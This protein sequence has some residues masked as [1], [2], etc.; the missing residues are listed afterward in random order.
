MSVTHSPG[1]TGNFP[2]F[3][4][5][6][7]NTEKT[8]EQTSE[9]RQT[10]PTVRNTIR[11]FESTK[12]PPPLTNI[13]TPKSSKRQIDDTGS[14]QRKQDRRPAK[15][16]Q[17]EP[18][19]TD[20]ILEELRAMSHNVNTNLAVTQEIKTEMGL[21]K[22]KVVKLEKTVEDQSNQIKFLQKE[23]DR[24]YMAANRQYLFIHGIQEKERNESELQ[25][26]VGRLFSQGLQLGNIAFD[27]AQRRGNPGP[28]PRPISVFFQWP[29]ERNS[30]IRAAKELKLKGIYINPDLPPTIRTEARLKRQ[31]RP[32]MHDRPA[33][34]EHQ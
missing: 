33:P 28:H 12:D 24:L 1:K 7:T 22:G 32:P 11:S 5:K 17:M 3:T 4:L 25:Q 15:L 26:E 13:G 21:L 19:G 14:D 18:N 31:Q 16:T 20:I 6:G 23:N 27:N 9:P 30:V 8:P 29:S 34:N 2:I 10:H